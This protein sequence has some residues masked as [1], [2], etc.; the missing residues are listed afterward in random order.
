MERV[1]WAECPTWLLCP[2]AVVLALPLHDFVSQPQPQPCKQTS[3]AVGGSG[4]QANQQTVEGGPSVSKP[5]NQYHLPE[6]RGGGVPSVV[7]RITR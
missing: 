6:V 5:A 1:T 2:V 3:Q 4:T 7:I